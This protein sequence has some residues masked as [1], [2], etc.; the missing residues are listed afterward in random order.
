MLL[1]GTGLAL[2]SLWSLKKIELGFNP[3]QVLT[4]QVAAPSQLKGAQIPD[5]YRQIAERIRAVPGVQHAAV[6]RD[7]PLNGVD[8][9]MPI[10][11]D[12]KDLPP[13]QGQV[14][15]R[16]RAVGTDYFITL[17]IAQLK[18]RSFNK[19]DSENSP[20]VAIVSQ[21]LAHE[22]WP[23]ESPI[24]K[25]IKP[26]FAGAPW[27]TVVGEVA[28]VRHWGSGVQIEPTAYYPYTQV[29]D[30]MRSL[31]ES[32]M[33]IA[34][35]SSLVQGD[36]VHSIKAAVAGLNPNVAAYNIESMD[37]LL[38]QS[39]SLRD[40]DLILL[41]AFSFLALSLAAVGVYA[42]MA[43]SVSQRTQEIGVRMALGAHR[44]D[45]LLLVFQQ[46]AKLAAAGAGAGAI[47]AVF[48]R[49][50]MA[51]YLYGLSSNN[52]ATLLM[53]PVV[54]IVIVLMACWIPAR[55]AAKI[56]PMTALRC[57]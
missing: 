1:I 52:A 54:M 36:L 25:R 16:Y 31:I 28:D 18:G 40:F 49:K 7:L 38:A 35:Q 46:G 37:S 11:T 26:K 47:G 53:V 15:T 23:D 41:G 39:G 9:S 22:Y 6:A 13:F 50:M 32:S 51:G 45:I 29:P 56:E 12:G 30:S 10:Q 20:A 55:R 5:F 21:S 24:G 48:L 42:V 43:Y 19:N 33:S 44:G 57:D 4:F 2:R 27:C 17:G 3:R 8:P 14:V 34:V